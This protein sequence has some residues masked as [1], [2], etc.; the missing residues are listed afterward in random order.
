MINLDRVLER[1]A[2]EEEAVIIRVEDAKGSTPREAGAVMVVFQ[3]GAF[4]GT[5]GGG[6]LEWHAL[7]EA[8]KMLRSDQKKVTI[9]K[10]LGPDLGQCC[11]GRMRLELRRITLDDSEMLQELLR[12]KDEVRLLLF[13]AG[14]VGKALVLALAPLP[15][16]IRWVDPRPSAFPDYVPHNVAIDA[17]T[18]PIAALHA[19]QKHDLVAVMTHS[20][21]L[22][23]AIVSAALREDRFAYVGLIGSGTKKA[24]F[25][26]QLR[27]AGLG[28]AARRRLICP[29]GLKE[30]GSKEP[31]AIAA[32]IAAQLLI[33]RSKLIERHVTLDNGMDRAG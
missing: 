2:D 12:S 4:S 17:S 15:F 28:D 7:A 14:H 16:S 19:A 20:H 5:I 31:A 3:N 33:E 10:A 25:M 30:I 22:D 29:I 24:R 21:A 9:D 8:Q 26:S 32:G 13:G 6:T 18:D 11:G 27:D 1:L 23:L